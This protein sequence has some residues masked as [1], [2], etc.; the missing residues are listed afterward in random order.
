MDAIGLLCVMF[1]ENQYNTSRYLRSHCAMNLAT[2]DQSASFAIATS[3]KGVEI[4]TAL[5]V[6]SP[7]DRFH[8]SRVF[9]HLLNLHA[10]G[11]QIVERL[12][13]L[14]GVLPA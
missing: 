7:T 6:L 4:T 8:L 5:D 13:V 9:K 12:S 10:P 3:L 1:L 2:R 11:P 14:L